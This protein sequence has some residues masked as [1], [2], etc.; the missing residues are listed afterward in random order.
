MGQAVG[1]REVVLGPLRGSGLLEGWVSLSRVQKVLLAQAEA[2]KIRKIGEA[3]AFVIEAIGMAE[4][5]GMKLKAEAL[6]QYGEAAKLALVLD[7]LPE[8]R[9]EQ[10]FPAPAKHRGFPR[11]P[12]G[13]ERS[14]TVFRG[15]TQQLLGSLLIPPSFFASPDR[16]QSGCSPLQSGRDPYS[17]RREQQRGVRGEP[18]AGRDPRVRAGHHRR[19]SHK[20]EPGSGHC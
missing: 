14:H 7:A 10:L 5:E 9:K 13:T 16:C 11:S 18:S 17:Q 6:Q 8:V 1:G 19:G 12:G 20:G 4:A 15:L 2:E 3:E